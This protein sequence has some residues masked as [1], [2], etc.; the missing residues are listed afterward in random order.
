M[1]NLL[2]VHKPTL[3]NLFF[4]TI[5]RCDIYADDQQKFIKLFL[6]RELTS[7]Q[8]ISASKNMAEI[9]Y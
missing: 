4:G 7:Q 2:Q 8:S 3:T 9:R 1:I 6:K 5:T